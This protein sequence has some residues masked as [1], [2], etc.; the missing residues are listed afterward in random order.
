MRGESSVPLVL[1]ASVT[2]SW[3]FED[4][5]SPQ[6]LGVLDMLRRDSAIVP[7]HWWFEI[8]NV[9]LLGERRRGGSERQTALFLDRL[10]M[11]PIELAEIPD[12]AKLISVARRHRLSFYDAAYLELAQRRRIA[13]ATLDHQLAAAAQAEGITLVGSSP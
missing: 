8:R 3:H 10:A 6:A 5:R 13:L 12:E 11:L 7:V 4:E 9:L 2:A 1:D